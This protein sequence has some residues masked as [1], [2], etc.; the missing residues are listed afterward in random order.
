MEGKHRPGHFQGVAMVIDRLFKIIEADKAY[1]G[2]KDFQQLT[3]IKHITKNL[4]FKTKII[5]CPIIRDKN[6][7]ALSSRNQLLEEECKVNAPKIFSALK[8]SKDEIKNFSI[9]E[10]KK[11]IIERLNSI[12]CFDVEYFDIVDADN[13]QPVEKFDKSIPIIGCIAVWAGNVRLIDNII[14][15]L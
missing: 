10:I 2:E 14:Y 8:A 11:S 1:F 12:A 5:G 4:G 6:G 15:N 13:L 3:I 7:L 9:D